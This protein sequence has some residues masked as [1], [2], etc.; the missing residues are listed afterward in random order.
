MLIIKGSGSF[1]GVVVSFLCK[2]PTFAPKAR[3]FS[4]AGIEDFASGSTVD[5]TNA[6]E[7]KVQIFRK[8]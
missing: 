3:P 8:A 1:S 6:P 4:Y 7:G 2:S 5:V